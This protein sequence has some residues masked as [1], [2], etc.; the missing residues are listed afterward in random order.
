MPTVGYVVNSTGDVVEAVGSL[1]EVL[2]Y[3]AQANNLT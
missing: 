2:K 3:V 1:S